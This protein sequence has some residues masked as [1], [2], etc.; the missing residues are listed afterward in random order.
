[1]IT[2]ARTDMVTYPGIGRSVAAATSAVNDGPGSNRG[3][4]EGISHLLSLRERA[5]VRVILAHSSPSG[6]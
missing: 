5:E 1:M 6:G 4:P 3:L 2:I